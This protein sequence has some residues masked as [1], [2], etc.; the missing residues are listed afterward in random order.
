MDWEQANVALDHDAFTQA[1]AAGQGG[2][3]IPVLWIIIAVI[4]IAGIAFT[5]TKKAKDGDKE[6]ES[7]GDKK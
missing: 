7:G 6:G 1:Q 5:V 2:F 4:I 3:H